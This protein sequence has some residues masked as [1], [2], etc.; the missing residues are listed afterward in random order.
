[1]RTNI[2]ILIQT[3]AEQKF[4]LNQRCIHAFN[5]IEIH[6]NTGK[7]VKISKKAITIAKGVYSTAISPGTLYFSV[8]LAEM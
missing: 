7:K 6:V 2:D 3:I 1:M 4:V 8:S 5:H